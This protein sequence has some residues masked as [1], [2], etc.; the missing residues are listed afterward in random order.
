M[1][2]PF[3][4]KAIKPYG[5]HTEA[6]A[7][8]SESVRK[9]TYVVAVNATGEWACSCPAWVWSN[10]RRNCKHI[11]QVLKWR[12][13]QKNLPSVEQDKPTNRFSAVEV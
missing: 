7:V 2:K 11:E 12:A 6:Y 4:I 1:N 8:P 9:F 13:T 3:E 10:P 5:E